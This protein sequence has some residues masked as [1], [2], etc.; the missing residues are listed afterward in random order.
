MYNPTLIN[1]LTGNATDIWIKSLYNQ[2]PIVNQSTR[3]DKTAFIII[4]DNNQLENT[5]V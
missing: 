5:R 2:V 3:P 4:I 1:Q